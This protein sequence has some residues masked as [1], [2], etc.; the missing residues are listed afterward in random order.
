MKAQ[1]GCCLSLFDFLDDE[2]KY[3]LTVVLGLIYAIGFG[4]WAFFLIESCL[5]NQSDDENENTVMKIFFG[6]CAVVVPLAPMV[7][8]V[9][10]DKTP[11][12]R[13]FLKL[14]FLL[15]VVWWSFV[16]TA[17]V[18]FF[19]VKCP[20]LSSKKVDTSLRGQGILTP[21]EEVVV[22]DP[23]TPVEPQGEEPLFSSPEAIALAAFYDEA[24]GINWRTNTN[25]KTHPSVCEWYG[26]ECEENGKVVGLD[27]KDNNMHGMISPSIGLLIDLVVFDWDSNYL[28]GPIPTEIC[29]L[30]NLR[31]FEADDNRLTGSV[32]S[33]LADIKILKEVYLQNNNFSG[34]MPPE[35]CARRDHR[36]GELDTLI[37]DC[38]GDGN[39]FGNEDVACESPECC[40]G[41]Q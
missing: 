41:C 28:T 29:N 6:I 26:V 10:F 14:N 4:S 40:S 20:E 36:G 5:N 30:T 24:N 11:K 25:W 19:S 8:L 1:Q 22:Q 7:Q 9:V 33:C 15:C 27:L 17:F 12:R 35:L 39:P 38:E 31:I 2:P 13:P 23:R 34:S 37:A 3:F 32:P 18:V 21:I 16:A